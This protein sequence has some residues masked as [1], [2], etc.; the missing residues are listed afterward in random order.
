[1]SKNFIQYFQKKETFNEITLWL[2][3]LPQR[4]SKDS[5]RYTKDKSKSILL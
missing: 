4:R 1:M 3:L 5:L 2:N